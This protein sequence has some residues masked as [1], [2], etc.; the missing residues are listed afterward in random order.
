[1]E[2]K[3]NKMGYA[4]VT[5]LLLSMAFPPM[6][7]MLIQALYNIV[8]SIFVAQ[9]S[10]QALSAI[11]LAFPIQSLMIAIFVGTNVGLNSLIARRLGEQRH[12]DANDAAA[13][14]LIISVFS[15]IFIA[16]VGLLGS[17]PFFM[18]MTDNAEIIELGCTYTMIVTGVCMFNSIQCCVEKMLQSTGNM[19]A[20]MVSHVI[21]CVVNIVLDPILIFGWF[22]IPAMGMAGAA[23]A[24]VTGQ[25]CGMIFCIVMFVKTNK[26]LN[27]SF[28]GFKFKGAIIKDIYQV[29]FPSIV[30]QSIGAVLT[31][32]MNMILINFSE[33]AVNVLGIYYKLQQFILMPTL[34]VTQGAMPII[35]YNFGAGNKKRITKTLK[36]AL[37][38]GIGIMVLGVLLF[39]LIPGTLLSMFNAD[40]ETL[41]IGITALRIVGFAFI[42]TGFAIVIGTTF[43]AV[44]RGFTS[45]FI[46]LCRQIIVL[47][48]IAYVMSKISLNA[49]WLAFPIAECVAAILVVFLFINLYRKV[50]TKLVPLEER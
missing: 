30:M 15:G 40:A 3:Q 27:I 23:I 36:M 44:G 13:H 38:F 41:E 26:T 12:A 19:V 31:T 24:T 21:G 5:P 2:T 49:V 6:I 29:G 9:I 37:V 45:L 14:G 39:E 32:L 34:G 18:M 17:R 10:S 33:A 7:S 25:A 4:P 28:K 42:P 35:G 47:L 48:P 8:D 46:S 1:M 22:G 16:L 20:P 11:S 50:F 43:Q